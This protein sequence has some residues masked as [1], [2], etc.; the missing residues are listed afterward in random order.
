M[1]EQLP[2]AWSKS[3]YSL[4]STSKI[5]P[6]FTFGTRLEQQ[7]FIHMLRQEDLFA[8]SLEALIL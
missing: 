3:L 7:T 1:Q 2:R 6:L 4:L 8:P 5:E